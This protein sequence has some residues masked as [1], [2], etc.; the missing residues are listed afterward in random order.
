MQ[1]L[2]ANIQALHERNKRVEKDKAW[3]VSLPPL[4]SW[5]LKRKA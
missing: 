4:K 5:W 1:N 2:E 3:E